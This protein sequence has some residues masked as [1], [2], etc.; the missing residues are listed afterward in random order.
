LRLRGFIV[1]LL[2]LLL[3]A[4]LAAQ[5]K[6]PKV[7]A[8]GIVSTEDDEVNGGFSPDGRD[9]YFAKVLPYTTFPRVGVLLVTHLLR[10]SVWSEPEVLSFSGAQ[11]YDT[12]PR[13]SPDGQQLFFTSARP[14][15]GKKARG[16]RIWR[17]QRAGEGWSAPEPV[18]EPVNSEESWNWGASVTRDGT[19]YFTSD[20]EE[21]FHP[22]LYRS[23]LVGGAYEKPSRLGPEI[24]SKFNDSDAFV[25]ADESK[26]FFVSS[27]GGAP[28]NQSRAGTL[29]GHGFQYPRGDLYVSV[30]RDGFAWAQ[31][32]HLKA[33]VNTEQ[34]EGSPSLSPDGK[35][36]F[37]SSERSAFTVPVQRRFDYRSLTRELHS[38]SNGH[39][40]V[41]SIPL[42]ELGL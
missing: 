3:A 20:R 17:S 13:L 32:Q 8:P 26:L 29:D 36:L 38:V 7:F 42:S 41:Y 2:F 35:T 11:A 12:Q 1:R 19:L 18:P 5:A 4:A 14:A 33:M 16:L 9:Y 22:Q 24:N 37:F 23:R 25:S 21:R 30:R 28:D 40:N 34:D 10:G 39:G 27:G 6:G 31:A 15:P